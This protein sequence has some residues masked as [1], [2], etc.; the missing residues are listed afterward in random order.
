VRQICIQPALRGKGYYPPRYRQA[1]RFMMKLAAPVYLRTGE[2]LKH[3]RLINPE[4]FCRALKEHQEGKYRLILL[5]RHSD[6]ADA[7]ALMQ[8][9]TH[10]ADRE[11]RKLGIRYPRA[12]H[13]FFLYGK[14]VLNWAGL[15]ARWFFPR[16]GH[17]PVTNRGYNRKSIEDIQKTLEESLYPLALAPEGQVT[18][19]SHRCFTLEGGICRMIDWAGRHGAVRI[20]PVSLAYDYGEK[21][22]D[23]LHKV[24]NHWEEQTGMPL[25][26]GT[27]P[28]SLLIEMTEK[29]VS[30]LEKSFP[31]GLETEET[32][33]DERI[34]ALNESIL[35]RGELTAGLRKNGTFLDRIFHLRYRGVDTRYP[36]YRDPETFTPWEKSASDYECIRAAD[37]I[38]CSQIADVLEYI[39]TGYIEDVP[40]NNRHCEYAL[41]ILDVV[42]RFRGGD[43]STRFTPVM[44]K[45]ILL[46]GD[47]ITPALHQD[48]ESLKDR[49]RILLAE[50][51]RELQ[52]LSSDIESYLSL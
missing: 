37:Y 15:P 9:V 38:R 40:L 29:T 23:V 22:R 21:R 13:A 41:N 8:A 44:R 36:E 34:Q 3:V 16:L 5:F 7:P 43:I 17:I 19:H 11:G 30:L 4:P 50:L 28:Y 26:E 35:H 52:S 45:A 51:E 31:T 14:D 6:K 2:H 48:G 47:L 39:Y 12:P 20:L 1:A 27:S 42:N 33:L 46:T 49:N 18:Y 25:K 32:D 10:L 24:R